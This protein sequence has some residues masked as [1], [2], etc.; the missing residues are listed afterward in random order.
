MAQNS[1]SYA[2]LDLGSNSFHLLIAS[3][4]DD[5]LRV[6]DRHKDM[7]RL[8]AGLDD[9]GR[10]SDAAQ[11]R[12]LE[13]LTKMADRLRGVPRRQ[14]RIVGTNRSRTRTA[15]QYYLRHRRGPLSLPRRRQRLRTGK[16]TPAC[17]RYWRRLYR[18]RHWHQHA[19][20]T[21]KPANG[22]R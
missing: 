15:H 13:S 3:F 1:D 17:P 4:H 7:V 8:A 21:R 14:I 12:A 16:T 5:K 10:L 22:L 6:I 20:S 11:E 9:D 2:A 19:T 18:A